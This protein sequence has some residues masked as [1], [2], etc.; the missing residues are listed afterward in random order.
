MPNK[1]FDSYLPEWDA[2]CVKLQDTLT[3]ASFPPSSTQ[4]YE[5]ALTLSRQ[6][7]QAQRIYSHHEDLGV[8]LPQI[9]QLVMELRQA[10]L[11]LQENAASDQLV[12][13]SLSL[14]IRTENLLRQSA[15]SV[16]SEK[17]EEGIREVFSYTPQGYGHR[18][19]IRFFHGNM[20]KTREAY[21]VVVCS[22]FRNN[23]IPLHNTLIG[24]LR[25]EKNISLDRLSIDPELDLRA[26][27]C[28]LSKEIE[29]NFRRIA[30]LELLDLHNRHDPAMEH[31]KL[32][33]GAF[34]TLKYLLEQADAM[35]IPIRSVALPILG[36]G[37]QRIS[38]EYILPPLFTQCTAMFSTIASLERIDF[39]EIKQQRVERI[40]ELFDQLIPSDH[41]LHPSIFISYSTKQFDWAHQM[42]RTLK[43]NGFANWIA[44]ESISPGSDYIREIPSAIACSK[45]LLLLLTEDAQRSN[46]VPNEVSSAIGA[47]K[48]LLPVQLYPFTPNQDFKFMLE[49]AQILPIW[50]TEESKRFD[51]VVAAVRH[52]LAG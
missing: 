41:V 23:Y 42:S 43:N 37:N 29:G 49:R 48:I 51:E 34:S 27:G 14:I 15:P 8:V 21:D 16:P 52:K 47:G 10:F 28:W 5:R 11:A 26:A 30:C 19:T 40:R 33:K 36:A 13:Q 12:S 46:W 2:L 32:L 24:A 7:A 18:K 44:P 50:Q 20:A 25:K 1:G 3:A 22:A 31:T 38:I 45:M 17:A 6:F 35:D 9:E 4:A 39:Y